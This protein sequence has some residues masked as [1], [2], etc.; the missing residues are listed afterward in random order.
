MKI[1]RDVKRI[2][3]TNESEARDLRVDG[4]D[5]QHHPQRNRQVP[6]RYRRGLFHWRF[7]LGFGKLSSALGHSDSECSLYYRRS[8]WRPRLAAVFVGPILVEE[9]GR[10][11]A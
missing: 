5:G 2:V 7:R 4:E 6:A 1:G 10:Q 3:V 8:V 9:R 11:N